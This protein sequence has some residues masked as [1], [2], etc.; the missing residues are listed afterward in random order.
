MYTYLLLVL[1]KTKFQF[2]TMVANRGQKHQ[3][4]SRRVSHGKQPSASCSR[5]DPRGIY[6]ARTR[7][8]KSMLSTL[9]KA[10]QNHRL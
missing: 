9:S 5:I 4:T 2:A 1:G 8:G 10:S 7:V 6:R 3:I